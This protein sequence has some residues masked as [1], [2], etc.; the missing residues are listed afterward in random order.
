MDDARLSKT[1][2]GQRFDTIFTEVPYL[3]PPEAAGPQGLRLFHLDVVNYGFL[4][5][6]IKRFLQKNIGQYVYS[7]GELEALYMGDDREGIRDEALRIMREQGK[8]DEKGTGSE[9]G[10]LLL[11]TFLEEKLAAP[12]LLSKVELSGEAAARQSACDGIHLHIVG[13][14]TE[15]PYYQLVFGISRMVGDLKGAITQALEGVARI[16]EREEHEVRLV[17]R[18]FLSQRVPKEDIDAV[19]RILIPSPEHHP[20]YDTAYGIF[21]GYSIGLLP[22]DRTPVQYRQAVAKKM[23]RDIKA[24]EAMIR[25]QIAAMGLAHRSFYF[26]ILPFMDAED[27]KEALMRDI[28]GYPGSGYNG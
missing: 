3:G 24:H 27:D 16:E 21:L 17:E 10:E 25:E 13:E 28:M 14:M 7:R 20:D 22:R 9:L 11:Y 5:R 12:K 2:K 18:T 6:D 8:P 4:R 19:K 26:Y 15:A 1:L 23:L